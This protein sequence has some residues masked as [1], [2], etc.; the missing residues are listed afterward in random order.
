MEGRMDAQ[1]YGTLWGGVGIE[2]ALYLHYKHNKTRVESDQPEKIF[3]KFLTF[4]GIED[5]IYP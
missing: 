2:W 3:G 1:T 5:R 4:H